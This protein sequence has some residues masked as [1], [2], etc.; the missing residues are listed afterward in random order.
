MYVESYNIVKPSICGGTAIQLK[1]KH[2]D[3]SLTNHADLHLLESSTRWSSSTSHLQIS[4]P[5]LSTFPK[6][7]QARL[8]FYVA[9]LNV[10]KILSVL[11]QII[12]RQEPVAF[13]WPLCTGVNGGQS[14]S[15][16][17]CNLR[18][19]RT[20]SFSWVFCI[21]F[22]RIALAEAHSKLSL[23][24]RVLEE[25]A[26][27]AVLLCENS[28]TLKHGETQDTLIPEQGF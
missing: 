16:V 24:N 28:I 6:K 21:G 19:A 9:R 18:F 8:I 27:I 20:Q 1:R 25:D 13:W 4:L 10:L 11:C 23:R 17:F 3:W 22:A 14:G 2:P 15:M 7:H 12:F 26:L 5:P